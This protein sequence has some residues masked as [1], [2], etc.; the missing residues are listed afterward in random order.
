[1][2]FDNISTVLT[3]NSSQ[4]LASLQR[5]GAATVAFG[6][7]VQASTATAG[8]VLRGVETAALGI[9]GAS[10][11]IGVAAVKSAIDFESAFTGTLK[12]VE[13]TEE[14]LASL[15]TGI[16]DMSSELPTAATEIAGVAEAAGQLGVETDNVL[17]FS[18][19]MVDLG[20]TTNL[21]AEEAAVALARFANITGT[22]QTDFD[23][24]G[25]TIVDLGNNFATTEAEIV[26]MSTRLAGAATAVG[27]DPTDI[28]GL[29]TA[30][31]SV[32]IQA[33]AGGSALTRVLYTINNAVQDGGDDLDAFAELA[34][35]SAQEF[36]R[37]WSTDPAQAFDQVV[38]GIGRLKD[39][40]GNVAQTLDDLELKG[41]RVQNAMVALANAGD[42]TADALER[43][44]AAWESNTALADEAALRYETAESKLQIFGNTLQRALIDVGTDALPRLLTI[45]EENA[46]AIPEL[47]ENMAEAGLTLVEAFSKSLPI[48]STFA[49]VIALI[50]PDLIAIGASVA[51][52]N[53]GL[54]ILNRV[55]GPLAT[56]GSRAAA[57]LGALNGAIGGGVAIVAGAGIFAWSKFNDEMERFQRAAEG[58]ALN[59]WNDLSTGADGATTSIQA[60]QQALTAMIE[61]NE[62]FAASQQG[63]GA[64][65]AQTFYDEFNFPATGAEGGLSRDTLQLLGIT[66][67]D[68]LEAAAQGE[69]GVDE[70]A[71]RIRQRWSDIGRQGT[72]RGTD[73]LLTFLSGGSFSL[74]GAAEVEELEGILKDLDDLVGGIEGAEAQYVL[75][76][77]TTGDIERDVTDAIREVLG[78]GST[79]TQVAGIVRDINLALSEGTASRESMA[80]W[81]DDLEGTDLSGLTVDE[82]TG[83]LLIDETAI[84]IELLGSLNEKARDFI[85]TAS[86]E[87]G[88]LT[89][90]SEL[91]RF[92]ELQSDVS[93]WERSR[94]A[95]QDMRQE[96]GYY[97]EQTTVTANQISDA[98][99]NAEEVS[100]GAGR[101]LLDAIDS[102]D[103]LT[104]STSL[105][106]S[107]F[108]VAAEVA[109]KY[110]IAAG[111]LPS[112]LAAT[113]EAAD[114][115]AA[116][117]SASAPSFDLFQPLFEDGSGFRYQ[118]LDLIKSEQQSFGGY[119]KNLTDLRNRG[120]DDLARAIAEQGQRDPFAASAFAA[121]AAAAGDDVVRQ[122]EENIEEIRVG[123]QIIAG[124][125][126]QNATELSITD[127]NM[128]DALH[129]G[130]IETME[131]LAERWGL[132][133]E[134]I[135]EA[136]GTIEP[137]EP[138]P[139]PSSFA[140]KQETAAALVRAQGL[141]EETVATALLE[142]DE[143]DDTL[144]TTLL[145]LA[146]F[147]QREA[148][149][150]LNADDTEFRTVMGY[151]LAQLG[152]IT[153]EQYE[154]LIGAD[155]DESSLTS[156]YQQILNATA[157]WRALVP[158]DVQLSPQAQAFLTNNTFAPGTL[159]TQVDLNR[160]RAATGRGGADGGVAYF[161]AGGLVNVKVPPLQAADPPHVAH[162][163]RGTIR[164]FNEPETG[165]EGYIPLNP[166]KRV[167]SEKIL[168]QIANMFGGRY[169]KD[170]KQVRGLADGG[171]VAESRRVQRFAQGGIV[172]KYIRPTS[173]IRND[174]RTTTNN[175]TEVHR[176]INFTGDMVM[177]DPKATV[178]YAERRTRL[179][180]LTG[181]R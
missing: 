25:S 20:E 123:E 130:H 80:S 95:I 11:G 19:V 4:Y 135:K 116:S 40:G 78:D 141:S 81:L 154:A 175:L 128:R 31:S 159:T 88:S 53:R 177:T 75:D 55:L 15:R 28:L 137:P 102:S 162:I 138:P 62:R 45:F 97:G 134:E 165:G 56:E 176:P 10:I 87:G 63:T 92:R 145:Q 70:L 35:T 29:S 91:N 131:S 110:G 72:R 86:L 26:A 146:G 157:S 169:V 12:T 163:A 166:A 52:A 155:V 89:L 100:A 41:V 156:A 2:A 109:N 1:M 44:Q 6:R 42:L 126:T 73:D 164:V 84:S 61:E 77:E 85:Q 105:L 179:N 118:N 112:V 144:T 170:D 74:G 178:E 139:D 59:A 50:P 106:S 125:I 158:V 152:L 13:G 98:F 173:Q 94:Q 171:I 43:S 142:T 99:D 124:L 129:E 14:Q 140:A 160:G 38:R 58:G 30:L 174:S 36:A 133:V 33:E 57:G 23:K 101:R 120:A 39:E 54:G 76:F 48:L 18:R 181:A 82:F 93:P 66:R 5:A 147:D 104:L 119:I 51:A 150:L 117:L 90:T 17:E 111:A 60:A 68:I 34:G 69:E 67:E 121:E 64:Q 71:E 132:T 107:E 153:E 9:G 96:L 180:A 113:Q 149:A 143:F 37:V 122:Y 168:A 24:L 32:G 127:N 148:Q 115:L 49:E 22:A 79:E 3:L 114:N 136:L 46:A 7:S 47:I 161:A 151:V 172:P 8:K 103:A 65:I 167:R 16:L 27:F 21:A 108:E 83:G